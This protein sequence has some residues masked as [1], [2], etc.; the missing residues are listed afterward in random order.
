MHVCYLCEQWAAQRKVIDWLNNKH[1]CRK[2]IEWCKINLLRGKCFWEVKIPSDC[3]WTWRKLLKLRE[4]ASTISK[5]K[6]GSGDSTSLWFSNWHPQGPLVPRYGPR[7]AYDAGLP[8]N[9]KVSQVINNGQWKW[10]YPCTW[11]LREII[12]E[13]PPDYLPNPV[14]AD[15]FMWMASKNK[16]YN[17]AATWNAL[18]EKSPKVIWH[19]LL[20]FPK[21]F[22]RHSFILWLAIK[23]RLNT[24]DKLASWGITTDPTCV[25]CG[26]E[27]ETMNHLFF[28]CS[29]SAEL[30]EIVLSKCLITKATQPWRNEVIWAVGKFSRKCFSNTLCKLAWA[31]LVYH[32]WLERNARIFKGLSTPIPTIIQDISYV[33]RTKLFSTSCH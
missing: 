31:A 32:I 22:P 1:I 24:K 10:A 25:L 26:Q 5:Y 13:H 15:E 29:F 3:S 20:W 28:Q 21:H 23:E 11:E 9:A 17:A 27:L 18:R 19:H 16:I 8:I 33:I 4:Q 2:V 12:L 14:V 30:K 6:I 7:I